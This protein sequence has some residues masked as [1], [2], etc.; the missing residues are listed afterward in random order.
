MLPDGEYKVA[1]RAFEKAKAQIR[2]FVEHP[3]RVVK[4][5]FGYRKNSYRGLAKND[6][7]MQILFGLANIYSL[8][9]KLLT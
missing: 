9:E 2:A 3:F 5:L 4:C 6:A 7:R 8:R 1:L